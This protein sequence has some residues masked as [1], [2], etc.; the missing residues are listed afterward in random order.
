MLC[1]IRV[2]ILRSPK[3]ISTY[4]STLYW[5]RT[6]AQMQDQVRNC[7]SKVVSQ[8]TT[9]GGD[10]HPM[11]LR[12]CQVDCFWRRMGPLSLTFQAL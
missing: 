10:I 11:L 9:L 12:R 8:F 1:S 5:K 4:G 6:Q 7:G 2:A 3:S